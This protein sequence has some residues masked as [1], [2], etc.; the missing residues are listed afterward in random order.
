[1]THLLGERLSVRYNIPW[2]QDFHDPW[3][4]Y[5]FALKRP[6]P[7]KQLELFYEEK[8]LRS[9][10]R[11]IVTARSLLDEYVDMYPSVPKEKYRLIHYGYSESAYRNVKPV[12][13]DRFTLVYTGTS[14]DVPVYRDFMQGLQEVVARRPELRSKI[15]VFFIGHVFAGFDSFVSSFGVDDFVKNLGHMDHDNCTRPR[16]QN[17]I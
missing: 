8:V 10:R 14:Y 16:G 2:V 13:F 11:V 3:T 7:L 9:A 15:Q 6:F 4:R 12:Q 1:M 5:S 17:R